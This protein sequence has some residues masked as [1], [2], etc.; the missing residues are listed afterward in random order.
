MGMTL[1][2][3]LL[4]LEV[5]NVEQGKGALR[6]R[7]TERWSYQNLRIGSGETVGASSED[8]YEMLYIFKKENQ[9]WLVDEIQFTAPPKVGTTNAPWVAD[10]SALHGTMAPSAGKETNA[11]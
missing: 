11:P 1:D 9:D 6:V 3:H 10:R 8:S 4:S 5:T 7:T 2:S